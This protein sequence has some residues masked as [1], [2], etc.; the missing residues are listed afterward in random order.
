[1][2]FVDTNISP[3]KYL[4]NGNGISFVYRLKYGHLRLLPTFLDKI[5][6]QK[7]ISLKF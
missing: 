4:K 7:D 2:G 3:K 1:M 6:S 5:K